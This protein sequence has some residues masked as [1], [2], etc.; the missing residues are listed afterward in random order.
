V[1]IDLESAPWLFDAFTQAD[2]STTRKYGGTGLG[3][4]I[5]RLLADRM[6]GGIGVEA[7]SGGGSVFWFTVS[8]PSVEGAPEAKRCAD[9]TGLRVLIVDGNATNRT[10]LEHYLSAWRVA[11]K[12]VEQ[13]DAAIGAL[14]QAS[15]CGQPFHVALLDSDLPEMDG[16][17]L[18]RALRAHPML[19]ALRLVI[20]S[21]SPVE[22]ELVAGVGVSAL[23]A[24]PARQAQLHRALAGDGP[25]VARSPVPPTPSRPEHPELM[26]LLAEDDEINR[27]VTAS[28]LAQR[29]L[30]AA[31]AHDGREA[32]QMAAAGDY[33]AIFM[34]CHMPEMDGYEATRR[35]HAGGHDRH[36]PIIALTAHAMPGDRERCL[37]AG[38]DDYIS[39]PIQ[40]HDLDAVLQRWLP[41]CERDGHTLICP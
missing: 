37:A 21:S 17:G 5:S 39:K 14:E 23:L 22:R 33:A 8:L 27:T 15:R 24:K 38:M 1:G 6:G 34:D 26:V 41:G 20:L 10:I 16:L 36:S 13:P 32:V 31:I 29:G 28:L 35:I 25:T 19:G 2:Q 9:L 40:K 12:S 18:A 11:C 7:R 3:L 4:A 30:C